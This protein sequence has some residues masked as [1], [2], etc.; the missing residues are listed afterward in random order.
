MTDLPAEI[1]KEER[2]WAAF[3]HLSALLILV[4]PPIGGVLGPL[5][6]WILKKDDM[7]FVR[8]QGRESLNFQ[9]TMLIAMAVAA[10]LMLVV[11]GFVLMPLLVLIDF[12]LVL[13]ATLQVVDGKPY[14][15]PFNLRLLQ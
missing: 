14:R 12:V 13:V 7:P 11:I 9:I 6:V 3:A 10:L 8:D 5:I 15:Y 2:Q 1:P 4:L